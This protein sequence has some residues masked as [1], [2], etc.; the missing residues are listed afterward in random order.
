MIPKH[1]GWLD[2]VNF[3]VL[4][5]QSTFL[6][7]VKILLRAQTEENIKKAKETQDIW[8]MVHMPLVIVLGRQR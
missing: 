1:F 4:A 7:V 2:S 6:M 3:S 8:A 5:I